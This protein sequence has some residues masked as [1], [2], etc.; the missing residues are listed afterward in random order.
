MST[1]STRSSATRGA[2]APPATPSV[3]ARG[4]GY[5]YPSAAAPSVEGVDLDLSPGELV[6]LTG[7]TGC[8][9]STLLRLLAGLLQRHGRGLLSGS[10]TVLGQDPA[11]WAPHQR[12]RALGFVGQEPGDQLV[13]GTVGDEV[14]FA[15]ESAGW[16]PERM[17][18]TVPEKLAAVG[19]EVSLERDPRELSG[20]QTQRLMVAAARGVGGEVLLLDEPLAQLDPL[21]AVELLDRLRGLARA[22]AT[23]LVV[24]HRLEVVLAQATRLLVMEAGRLVADVPAEAVQAGAPVLGSLRRLGL[25]VPRLVDLADRLGLEVLEDPSLLAAP[26]PAASVPD[27]RSGDLVAELPPTFFTWPGSSEPALRGVGLRVGV[28]ERVALLGGNGAGKSTLLAALSGQLPGRRDGHRPG[29]VAVPQDPDLALFLETVRAELS[30]GPREHGLEGAAL[31]ARVRRAAEALSVEAL[32]DRAPQALSRGQ[33]LRTA[34]AAALSC[35]PR[36]LLLDEPTSG[37]D[38]DQVDRM[39]GAL[40]ESLRDG[41]LVFATHDLDLALREATRVV[42][43]D[44]GRI[45]AQGPPEAVLLDLPEG[46]PLVLP[47][48]AARCRERG[49]SYAALGGRLAEAP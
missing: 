41:G 38:Q 30:Y 39:M 43:L 1:P 19:L 49:L 44:G 35:A 34:V 29:C 18:R 40:R 17:A 46:L 8:G 4:L 10:V 14:A 37:Q 11:A 12:V 6:L 5:R 7:P 26:V 23:V 36:L 2:T 3:Q 42:V 15:M 9:K 24:E 48:L 21:G 16:S 33:R 20:G 31:E 45:V 22:G 32:L 47:P 13:A 27:D 28:G 25:T